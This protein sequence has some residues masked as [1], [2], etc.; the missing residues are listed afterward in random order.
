MSFLKRSF[1]NA[2]VLKSHNLSSVP[3]YF[4][5]MAEGIELVRSEACINP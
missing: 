2:N 5:Y 1:A 4:S 3:L